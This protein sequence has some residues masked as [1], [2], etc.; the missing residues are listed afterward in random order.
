MKNTA[1]VAHFALTFVLE[2]LF[3]LLIQSA[4]VVTTRQNSSILR[5]NAQDA[6]YVL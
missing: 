2:R 4:R 3:E 5:E 6:L 1:R